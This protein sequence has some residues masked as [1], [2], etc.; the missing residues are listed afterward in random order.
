MEV[1]DT[2]EKKDEPQ[3]SRKAS[4]FFYGDKGNPF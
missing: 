4:L 1:I 2:I 3:V